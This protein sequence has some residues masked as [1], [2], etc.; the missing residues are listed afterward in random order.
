MR[1]LAS[2]SIIA[3]EQKIQAEISDILYE[4]E[5]ASPIT[6]AVMGLAHTGKTSTISRLFKTQL[7]AQ[8]LLQQVQS[9]FVDIP[10]DDVHSVPVKILDMPYLTSHD[11]DMQLDE[12]AY[13]L[14]G[15]DVILWIVNSFFMISGVEYQI[16]QRLQCHSANLVI[17]L[18]KVDLL[19]PYDW[20]EHYHIP[21]SQQLEN[22]KSL[23]IE[24]H[25]SLQYL[26]QSVEFVVPYSARYRMGLDDLLPALLK[27]VPEER[28]WRV[29]DFD[30]KK[31]KLRLMEYIYQ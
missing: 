24:E 6:V 12:L 27:S 8:I 29:G 13:D 25:Q 1:I 21:S 7:P 26:L 2:P 14:Q 30:D 31:L 3:Y 17:G 10:I 20:D 5:T 19:P 15:C 18:N 16:L 4:I 28:Q 23:T 11:F 22:I 9:H